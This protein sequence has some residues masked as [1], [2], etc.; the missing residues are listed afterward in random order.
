MV[1]EPVAHHEEQRKYSKEGT[2]SVFSCYLIASKLCL[3]YREGVWENNGHFYVNQGINET[4]DD[5]KA[6]VKSLVTL[7]PPLDQ[8][9]GP[10]APSLQAGPSNRGSQVMEGVEMNVLPLLHLI[11]TVLTAVELR[12]QH[13]YVSAHR[14]SS[15]PTLLSP[16]EGRKEACQMN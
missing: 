12:A 9:G 4:P 10:C 5:V 6:K 8:R 2:G 7:I 3:S 13:V 15:T 11:S 1:Y 16:Q 14:L